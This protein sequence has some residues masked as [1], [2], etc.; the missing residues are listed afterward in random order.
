LPLATNEIELITLE[1]NPCSGCLNMLVQAGVGESVADFI[2]GRSP[3]TVG[4]A[5]YL[6]K[7]HQA[8]LQYG[9][10]LDRFPI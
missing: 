10:V 7:V 4:S 3:T 5:H 6:N 8:T 2:Q 1:K 9:R